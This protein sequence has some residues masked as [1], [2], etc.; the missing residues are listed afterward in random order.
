MSVAYN[1]GKGE[2]IANPV[3]PPLDTKKTGEVS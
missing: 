2:V 1:T 3:A